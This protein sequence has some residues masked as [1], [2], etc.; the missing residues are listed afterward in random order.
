MKYGILIVGYP[1]AEVTALLA[2]MAPPAVILIDPEVS[3]QEPLTTEDLTFLDLHRE[4]EAQIIQEEFNLWE[5]LMKLE[6]ASKDWE[7]TTLQYQP[8][9]GKV[10]QPIKNLAWMNPALAMCPKK[11]GKSQPTS[12]IRTKLRRNLKREPRNPKGR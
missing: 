4:L 6:L 2:M 7:K 8:R 3:Q 1:I 11:M 9:Q 10:Y 12:P 5:E